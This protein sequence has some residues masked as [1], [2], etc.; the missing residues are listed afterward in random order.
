MMACDPCEH[1]CPRTCIHAVV[2]VTRRA[3]KQPA[4][5][6]GPRVLWGVAEGRV[7]CY[8]SSAGSLRSTGGP[9]GRLRGEQWRWGK[10]CNIWGS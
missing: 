5:S 2:A 3:A 1:S 4:L 8:A 6:L 7:G 9:A 10:R